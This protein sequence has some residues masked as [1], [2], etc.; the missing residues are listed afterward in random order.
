MGNR[1][2]Y[3]CKR[4]AR[5]TTS[6]LT[7]Q[8]FA[9]RFCAFALLHFFTKSLHKITPQKTA[10]YMGIR[11]LNSHKRKDREKGDDLNYFTFDANLYS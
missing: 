4:R 10:G 5:L 6:M 8:V 9:T 7:G 3:R 11:R 2:K 1:P